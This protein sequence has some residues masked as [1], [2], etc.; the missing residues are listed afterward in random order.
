M[1]K[2][3]SWI[4]S[5]LVLLATM[6]PA[7]TS[8]AAG[9]KSGEVA[10][11]EMSQGLAGEDS[12]SLEAGIRA[13]LAAQVN[14]WNRGDLKEYMRGYWH[15][16]ELTFF[17]GGKESAGWE[18]AYQRYR[19][20]YTGKDKQMGKLNFANMRVEVLSPEAAF[21][22][23]SWQLTAKDGSKRTGLFTVV[24]RKL[25]EGWRIIHDHSS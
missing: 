16:P 21:V 23:G 15:S 24:L 1:G 7:K 13:E 11:P 4:V 19:T 6:L 22:R 3:L 20:A 25:D 14:A 10:A 2:K 18:A 8:A 12:G 5:F 9:I 17:A